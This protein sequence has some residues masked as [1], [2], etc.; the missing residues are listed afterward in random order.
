MFAVRSFGRA[1][2]AL[3]V[4][5]VLA[6]SGDGA[7][8]PEANLTEA[9]IAD[10][11]SALSVLNELSFGG[12]LLRSSDPAIVSAALTETISESMPCPQGG[13]TSVSGSFT[14]NETTYAMSADL[15][16]RYSNCGVYSESERLW[17]FNGDPNIRTRMSSTFNQT[18]E[19][20]T[21]T[22]T[23]TGAFRFTSGDLSGRC[24][25]NLAMTFGETSI[26]VSGT[27]CGQSYNETVP[28]V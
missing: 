10:A 25:I 21:F 11:Y 3:P 27:I 2:R 18:A 5:A 7:T 22:A 28:F 8:A 19:T 12:M 1:L 14:I 4:A 20:F 6:C 24:S 23:I 15:R 26:T 17:I 13:T 9:E 16:Q